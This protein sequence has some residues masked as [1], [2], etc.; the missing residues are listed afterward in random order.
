MSQKTNSSSAGMRGLI[1]V[2]A[3]RRG[4]AD[5]S[6]PPL[7]KRCRL[8]SRRTLRLGVP[9]AFPGEIVS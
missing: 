1:L 4:F 7:A 2:L 8:V 3:L 9:R 5:S 6:P